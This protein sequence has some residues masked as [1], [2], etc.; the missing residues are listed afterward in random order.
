MRIE[1]S[2]GITGSTRYVETRKVTTLQ[3][4]VFSN[5]FGTVETNVVQ[6][7][8]HIDGCGKLNTL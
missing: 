5:L 1:D 8:V 2:I 4:G 7:R 6:N 3:A